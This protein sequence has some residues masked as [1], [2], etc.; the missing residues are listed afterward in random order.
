MQPAFE[1]LTACGPARRGRLTLT[2]GVVDTPAFM[3]VGTYGSVKSMTP[4][5]L[6]TVGAQIV[7]GNKIGRAHV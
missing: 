4:E 2:H 5:D 6:V 3:P 1:L 7:L